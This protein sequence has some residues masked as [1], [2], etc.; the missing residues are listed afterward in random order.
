[1]I[2]SI[3]LKR[4]QILVVVVIGHLFLGACATN[5]DPKEGG[6]INGAVGVFGGVYGERVD[7][8]EAQRDGLLG[9]QRALEAEADRVRRE[10][11]DVRGEL[12]RAQMRLAALEARI[13]SRRR[14]LANEG[15]ARQAASRSSNLAAADA[16]I[17]DGRQRIQRVDVDAAAVGSLR[18]EVN[19]IHDQIDEIDAMI[20]TLSS[21]AI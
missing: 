15:A 1:M 7:A 18:S 21:P 16:R 9:E 8:L 11:D 5:P 3:N 4:V 12:T 20:D 6:F 10:R 2:L 19:G 14:A 17:R 13:A